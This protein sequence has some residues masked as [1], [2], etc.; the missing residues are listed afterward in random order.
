[1]SG[2]PSDGGPLGQYGINIGPMIIGWVFRWLRGKLDIW[3]GG[4]LSRAYIRRKAERKEAKKQNM[5]EEEKAERK[6]AKAERK[7][8][9]A[10]ARD[11]EVEEELQRYKWR[12]AQI[13]KMK[14]EEL[15]RKE[16][17]AQKTES[18]PQTSSSS[19]IPTDKKHAMAAAA[20]LRRDHQSDNVDDN[21]KNSYTE[22]NSETA[23]D[24]L[25]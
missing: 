11:R 16:M 15:Q 7:A 9:R 3:M 20:E 5:T 25:D 12:A 19:H 23:F 13:A 18:S 17:N 8:E 14:E 22:L 4:V 6:M 1:M 24:D 2:A 21:D 10:A